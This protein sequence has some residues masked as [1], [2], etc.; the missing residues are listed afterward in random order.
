MIVIT[1]LKNSSDKSN[2]INVTEN[3]D[4]KMSDEIDEHGEIFKSLNLG[5]T[6]DLLGTDSLWIEPTISRLNL[7]QPFTKPLP[8]VF[9]CTSPSLPLPSRKILVLMSKAIL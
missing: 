2:N 4:R 8:P 9:P 1:K 5:L 3:I 7:H 6:W